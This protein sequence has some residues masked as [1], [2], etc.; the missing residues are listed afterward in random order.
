MRAIAIMVI[1]LGAIFASGCTS[2]TPTAPVNESTKDT[3]QQ[4]R[5]AEPP[6][7]Y[8]EL[9]LTD[10]SKIGGEYVSENANF[11]TI[12]PLY[13]FERGSDTLIK[14]SGTEIGVKIAL[15]NTMT[16]ITDPRPFIA[17]KLQEQEEAAAAAAKARENATKAS[18]AEQEKLRAEMMA[19]GEI[20]R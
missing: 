6:V 13:V 17:V 1:V 9:G 16:N 8:V 4:Q 3:P 5:P 15:V 20:T 12:I 7:R 19:R 18:Q 2:N 14:G 11:V 10:G